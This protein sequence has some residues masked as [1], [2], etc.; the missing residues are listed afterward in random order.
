MMDPAHILQSYDRVAEPYARAF[1]GELR[2]KPFDCLFLDSVAAT[3]RGKGP[4]VELG[5]G[6]GHVAAYLHER[7]VD[8]TGTDLSPR[9]VGQ[10]QGLFPAVPFRTLDMLQLDLPDDSVRGL[11]AFYA[12]VN[13]DLAQVDIAL[14][15]MRRVLTPGGLLAMSFHAGQETH[16]VEELLGCRVSMDFRFFDPADMEAR[17]QRAGLVVDEMTVRPPYPEEYPSH[18]AYLLAQA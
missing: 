16:H 12:I 13:F 3:L 4:V 2:H 5:C 14:R 15:E 9:M 11:V 18:R 17:L 10:A 8:V 1:A 7:G 6:P